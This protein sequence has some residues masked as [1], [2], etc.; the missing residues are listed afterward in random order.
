MPNWFSIDCDNGESDFIQS[1][2]DFPRAA[3]QFGWTPCECRTTDGTIPCEHRT[4][5]EMI[6]EAREFLDDRIGETINGLH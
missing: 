1:E 3:A 6:A 4:V 5:K 2:W